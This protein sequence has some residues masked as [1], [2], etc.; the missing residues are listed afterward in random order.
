[1]Y[2]APAPLADVVTPPAVCT[3][4]DA[5][6]PDMTGGF[7][8]LRTIFSSILSTGIGYTDG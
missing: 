2:A 1:M 4:P 5:L 6:M 3:H 8:F 7:G